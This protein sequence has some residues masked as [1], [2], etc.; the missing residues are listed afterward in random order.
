MTTF[1]LLQGDC[2]EMMKS[3]PDQSVDLILTD[4]PY[5]TTAC[6]W[7]AVVPLEP[8]WAQLKRILKPHRAVVMTASQPFTST[9]VMSNIEWFKYC[10]IWEKTR[11]TGHVHAKNKPMKRHE[12]VVVFSSGTTVHASQSSSR[13]TYNPQGLVPMPEGSVRN[14]YDKG[15]DSVMSARPSHK[16]VT[17]YEFTGYPDSILKF[18]NPNNNSLHPTQKPVPLMEYLIRTYSNEG[19]T[20]LDF[21]MGS[22]TTGVAAG[23]TD[24]S[25]IGIELTENYFRI[26]KE[27]IEEAYNRP[28]ERFFT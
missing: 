10:L 23:N 28:L 13:M 15:S 6:S 11:A 1:N 25:F 18:A 26:A 24:R 14:R 8:M 16:D 19:E 21:T 2:L 12:D 4:P 17:P 22:G 9:L 27:R 5:G 7:D 3:L 20:V